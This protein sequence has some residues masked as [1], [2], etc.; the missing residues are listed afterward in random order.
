MLID[1]DDMMI[2]SDD[3]MNAL[4]LEEPPRDAVD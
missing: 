3:M 2:D 4:K 1:S